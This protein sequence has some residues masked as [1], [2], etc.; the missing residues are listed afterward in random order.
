MVLG[1]IASYLD[2][3]SSR[4]MKRRYLRSNQIVK[5][6]LNKNAVI[7]WICIHPGHSVMTET[8]ASS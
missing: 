8:M 7:L 3:A 5:I 1:R 6:K 4:L 2:W